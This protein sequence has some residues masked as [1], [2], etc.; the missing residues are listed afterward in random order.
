MIQYDINIYILAN[1]EHKNSIIKDVTLKEIYKAIDSLKINKSTCSDGIPDEYFKLYNKEWG[2][3]LIKLYKIANN[4]GM[5]LD[6]E[7][8]IIT[9]IFKKMAKT[10]IKLQTIRVTKWNL[11]DMGDNYD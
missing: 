6:W 5:P 11:Q 2:D 3:I 7:T 10:N 1:E 4:D 8:G 9:L